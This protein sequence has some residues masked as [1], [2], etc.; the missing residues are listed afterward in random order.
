[1]VIRRM[2]VVLC[3]ENR[4]HAAATN[5]YIGLGTRGHHGD[6]ICSGNV[7]PSARRCTPVPPRTPWV[8]GS[9][10]RVRKRALQQPF[11]AAWVAPDGGAGR[12]RPA[13]RC[14]PRPSLSW[15]W[16]LGTVSRF[17]RETQGSW[18][19][20]CVW[21]TKR[22][23][24]RKDAVGSAVPQFPLPQRESSMVRRGS[25]VRVRQRASRKASK[26]P[27][28]LAGERCDLRCVGHRSVPK[29]CPH[30][31]AV[32]W[33]LALTDASEAIEHLHEEVGPRVSR[34]ANQRTSSTR[35]C[36]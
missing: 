28:F 21:L 31:R 24:W 22:G 27:F 13:P 6:L 3:C 20:V 34:G 2:L 15:G 9:P 35:W 26:W 30:Q 17:L 32:S 19:E 29:T 5:G 33:F 12:L 1:V 23:S 14:Q 7:P 4:Q 8:R 25:T 11:T 18:K 36:V 10:V 16:V